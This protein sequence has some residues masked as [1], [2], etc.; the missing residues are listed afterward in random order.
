MQTRV[1]ND[2]EGDGFDFY[3]RT[4]CVGTSEKHGAG[5]GSDQ[6]VFTQEIAQRKA[7]GNDDEVSG[8]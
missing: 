5:S 4:R 6:E 2:V 7:H 1:D 8:H 3:S